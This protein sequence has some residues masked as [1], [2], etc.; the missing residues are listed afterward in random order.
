[1]VE[2]YLVSFTKLIVSTYKL[3]PFSM[4]LFLSI[5]DKYFPRLCDDV[6][7][8]DISYEAE[9]EVLQRKVIYFLSGQALAV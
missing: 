6:E 9:M 7:G 1:M 2:F 8:V 3:F 4:C 5:R